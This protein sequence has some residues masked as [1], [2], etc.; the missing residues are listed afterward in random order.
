ML[1]VVQNM[2]EF[3]PNSEVHTI[4][5]RHRTDLHV[6]SITLTKYQKGVYCSGVKVFNHLTQNI[7]S[8]SSNVK[9]FKS[10]LKRFHL[11]G[12]FYTPDEYFGWI[13]MRD[14][15]TYMLISM[16]FLGLLYILE[17]VTYIIIYNELLCCIVVA[18]SA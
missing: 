5:T 11:M 10:A 18:L 6:P 9:S 3:T 8:L 4:N 7:K 13:S 14:L 1:F 16:L 2:E 12:S 17:A 15:N